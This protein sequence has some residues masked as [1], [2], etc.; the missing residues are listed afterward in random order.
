M[1]KFNFSAGPGALPPNV[2]QQASR[3]LIEVPEVGL[4]LLGISH[5]SRWFG[6]VVCE[7][8]TL[9]RELLNLPEN[10]H[11]LFLQGGATLQFS[12]VAATFLRNKN[13]FAEYL[14]T[15]YWSQQCLPEARKEGNIRVLYDGQS[16][17]FTR[18]P[19]DEELQHSRDAAYF[20]YISN[21][22]VEGLQFGRLPGRDDVRRVCDMSSDFLS[23]PIE[24]EKFSLIYAHA[25]KNL[26]P[27]GVTIVVLRDDV[28]AEIPDGLPSM[29]DYRPHVKKHSVFNTP[30]TFAIYVVLL[31]LRWLRH[32]IGGL[33]KMNC[34][35]QNKA[36]HLYRVLDSSGNFYRGRA[37]PCSRSL[38]NVSFYLPTF[39][40]E[41]KFLHEAQRAGFYGLDG[42]RSCGGL[43][44]SLYNAV[45]IEAVESLCEFMTEFQAKHEK[46][47]P[48]IFE[49]TSRVLAT[50]AIF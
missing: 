6:D 16:E 12:A 14:Q 28:L 25:Q 48:A 19:K 7:A 18:L 35:N 30:P 44:A 20:H 27:A 4:P 45:S 50:K 5:R 46:L 9:V 11:V 22:T 32:E 47:A 21:E 13:R 41:E 24:A 38:M 43:R 26:G 15:G 8:E 39:S 34:I 40:L 29:M 10:Y 1:T 31:V 36:A 37:L 3:A 17:G 33:E 42:H 23:R 49:T 2:E